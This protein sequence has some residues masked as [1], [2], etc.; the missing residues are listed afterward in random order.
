[1]KALSISR[2]VLD[3]LNGPR[4]RGTVLGLGYI[5][6]GAF[7]IAVTKPGAARMPNGVEADV[8]PVRGA[9]AEIGGG[10]LR[11]DGAQ[12]EA[13]PVW[14]PVP[15]VVHRPEAA[16]GARPDPERLAG[17]GPG[18]TPA[19]DDILAGYVAG[20]T[21]FHQRE[22]E[23]EAIA[24]RAAQL[25]T[26]LSATL[27]RHAAKGELPEPAHAWLERGDPQPLDGFGHS[28]GRCLMLG[29]KLAVGA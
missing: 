27:L 24:G 12:I 18:L 8:S 9:P 22:A 2:P 4:R 20:L 21:L 1:L 14:E 7:V 29:L 13:G 10:A 26:A 6:F 16:D 5:D 23:A 25:T 19:G 11:I 15:A 17:R 3:V 28:S